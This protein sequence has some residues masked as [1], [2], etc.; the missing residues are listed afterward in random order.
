MPMDG[1]PAPYG[2]NQVKHGGPVNSDFSQLHPLARLPESQDPD[3]S[4]GRGESPVVGGLP[5]WTWWSSGTGQV[6]P[7]SPGQVPRW[8][9]SS[10]VDLVGPQPREKVTEPPYG[11]PSPYE[12]FHLKACI[13]HL[14]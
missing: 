3:G 14:L 8:K 2:V 1:T 10:P 4:Q 6:H 12:I 13:S 11:T 7:A 5:Q 9:W